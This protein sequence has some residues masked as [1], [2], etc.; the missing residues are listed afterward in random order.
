MSDDFA[1]HLGA[2]MLT[3]RQSLDAENAAMAE[4]ANMLDRYAASKLELLHVA[5]VIA[6]GRQPVAHPRP[7][8]SHP[9]APKPLAAAE[10]EV[11]LEWD[12]FRQSNGNGG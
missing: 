11:E 10:M 7:I 1:R 3:A 2:L 8:Q 6:D 5:A 9:H 4:V 12:R